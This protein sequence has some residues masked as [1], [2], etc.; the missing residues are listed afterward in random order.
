MTW[1]LLIR[2]SSWLSVNAMSMLWLTP[3]WLHSS[4]ISRNC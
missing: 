4:L 3:Q 1:S 2:T